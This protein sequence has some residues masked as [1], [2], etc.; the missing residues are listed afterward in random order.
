MD[1]KKVKVLSFEAMKEND[2]SKTFSEASRGSLM[3]ELDSSTIEK[4]LVAQVKLSLSSSS[5][6]FA[7]VRRIGDIQYVDNYE[8]FKVN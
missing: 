2:R 8:T 3:A 6:E 1:S 4:E 7:M 5:N